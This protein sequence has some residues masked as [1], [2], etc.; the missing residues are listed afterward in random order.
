MHALHARLPGSSSSSRA[1]ARPV[2]LSLRTIVPS[3]DAKHS[4]RA[5]H[6]NIPNTCLNVIPAP[7]KLRHAPLPSPND[8]ALRLLIYVALKQDGL[9]TIAEVAQSYGI[10]RNHLIK[11]AYE[12]GVAGYLETVRRPRRRPA[13]CPAHGIDQARRRR[14]ADRAR[15]G[16]RAG[17]QPSTPSPDP[18]LLRFAQRPDQAWRR[19]PACSIAI[20]C[21]ISSSRRPGCA[22]CCR[23]IP[24]FRSVHCPNNE[25]RRAEASTQQYLNVYL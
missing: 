5:C 4:P 6:A 7:R 20:P 1:S 15:H 16:P 11:I 23:S 22:V 17:A 25:Q 19:S 12:L 10:M 18:A 2:V 8:Y 9:A 3:P 14:A 13:P 24:V 21:A